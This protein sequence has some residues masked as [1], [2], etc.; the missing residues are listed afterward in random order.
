MSKVCQGFDINYFRVGVTK[1][2]N[3]E[4]LGVGLEC[5]LNCI[6]I[7]R[8]YESGADA[9][10]GKSMLQKVVGTTVDVLS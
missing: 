2:L 4:E 5:C 10:L 8:I 1:S 9:I 7:V 6:Q 3:E